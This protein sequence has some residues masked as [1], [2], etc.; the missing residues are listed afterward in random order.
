M[1]TANN[2]VS[3]NA[4]DIATAYRGALDENANLRIQ[5]AALQRTILELQSKEIIEESDNADG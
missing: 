2:E 5:N 3:V 1:T 4:N